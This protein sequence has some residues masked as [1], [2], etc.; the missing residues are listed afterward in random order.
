MSDEQRSKLIDGLITA[1][2]M[3]PLASGNESKDTFAK[4]NGTPFSRSHSANISRQER[5]DREREC[6]PKERE[7]DKGGH[8]HVLCIIQKSTEMTNVKIVSTEAVHCGR[9][10]S[11]TSLL[12][13]NRVSLFSLPPSQKTL[14][15][16]L[17]SI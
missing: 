11:R 9:L 7:S 8:S 13:P 5:G 4:R 12:S 10:S 6:F 15:R 1:R 16:L 17:Y 14:C 2:A 3:K